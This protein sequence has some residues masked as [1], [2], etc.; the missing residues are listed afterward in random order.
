MIIFR[1]IRDKD[2]FESYYKT[3]LQKRLLGNRSLS[4][5]MERSMIT[6]LKTECGF[7]F[8]S[9]LEGMFAD[10]NISKDMMQSFNKVSFFRCPLFGWPTTSQRRSPN[11]YWCSTVVC[12]CASTY[13]RLVSPQRASSWT[14]W[15]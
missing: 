10:L 5:D 3:H 2:V 14:W 12:G 6:K 4:S 13:A 8:T 9:K 11:L 15:Y 1:Y 7:Q